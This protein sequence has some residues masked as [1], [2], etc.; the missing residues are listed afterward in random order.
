MRRLLAPLVLHLLLAS[1]APA[2]VR[3]PAV[4]GE[5]MVLQRDKPLPV[6]GEAGPEEP[7]QVSLRDASG[8]E[9]VGA[10]TRSDVHG[11]FRVV[12]APLPAH[13]DPLTLEVVAPSG[14]VVLGDVLVGDVWICGGQSNMEWPLGASLG[15]AEAV[16]A[17]NP[18]IRLIKAPHRLADRPQPSIDARWAV[19]TPQAAGG[20]SG[21]GYFFARRMAESLD[22]PVGLLSINWGGTHIEPWIPLEALAQHPTFAAEAALRRKAREAYRRCE[23][24]ERAVYDWEAGE[25]YGALADAYWAWYA[26]HDEGWRNEAWKPLADPAASGWKMAAMPG[27]LG[28]AAGTEDLKDFD[29]LV[30]LRR[31]IDL[32]NEWAG[33]DLEVRLGAIDDSD[34]TWWNGQVVG[35]VTGQSS[36]PRWYGVPKELAKAGS[37]E[38]VIALVDDGG[39]GGMS[40][41]AD[42]LLVRP[43]DVPDAKPIAL[44]GAWLLRP[45]VVRDATTPPAPLA[46]RGPENPALAFRSWGSMY[47]GMV[48]PFVPFAVRGAIWYQGESNEDDPEA[49]RELLPLLIASWRSAWAEADLPFGIVQLANYRGASD[50]PAPGGWSLVR[51][52]QLETVQTV[53]HTGLAVAIDVGDAGDIHPRDKRT[54]GER[55]AR[56]A[57]VELG[58]SKEECSGPVYRSLR[59]YR[60]DLVLSFDHAAGLAT[61]DGQ[62]PAGFAIA[63]ADGRFVWATARIE[64][65]TVRVTAP[66]VA[67]PVAV[68]Y[69]WADNPA[70]A[71][72]VNGAGLPASPFRTD[73]PPLQS[74]QP[75]R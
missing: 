52:A 48:A 68:R 60:S 31:T 58:A 49:Y 69:A 6:W 45:G 53:P 67:D 28:S 24:H 2:D 66:S 40:W 56:W 27:I 15:G 59:H 17:A 33:H 32:P 8:A 19:A 21:V 73:R 34:T 37:N 30:W 54:V 12:L 22:V 61:R 3:L 70:R 25:A 16:A 65:E 47:D 4:F 7:V 63:G 39:G 50:E 55:L 57:L 75:G 74:R 38:L 36:A 42:T 51:D 5:S 62:R 18:R 72:L 23:G 14:K 41:P 64:G 10:G 9:L 43:R 13:G 20:F 26:T 46:P 71:N 1:P 29:G 44:G 35:R 11:S